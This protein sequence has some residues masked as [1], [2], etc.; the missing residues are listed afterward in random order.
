MRPTKLPLGIGTVP[1]MDSRAISSNE[2]KGDTRI[3]Q[4][5]NYYL[6]R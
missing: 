6:N 4:G 5:D 3:H 2:F 1:V